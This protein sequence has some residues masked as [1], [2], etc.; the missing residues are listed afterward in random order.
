ML[1]SLGASAEAAHLQRYQAAQLERRA[2][3]FTLREGVVE[4][5]EALRER[6][7]HLGIVSNIDE[8]QLDYMLEIAQI[9]GHF[10]SALSSERAQSCKPDPG[11]FAVALQRAGCEA[12][13]ALFV[14]DTIA[15]DI[16]G[17][18][19]AGMRSVLIWSRV[20]RDPPA[21]EPRPHHVIRRTSE[22]LALV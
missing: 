21:E 8:D 4:T 6:G 16:V 3:D 9:G 20:D 7:M 18:N 22:L 13:E 11:I 12:R 1:E 14:G 5:L 19:R 10:D 15:Q 17:A 2:R